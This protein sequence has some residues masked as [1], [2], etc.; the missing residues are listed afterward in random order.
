M[1]IGKGLLL[2]TVTALGLVATTAAIV[3][4]YKNKQDDL[5]LDDDD[6]DENANE[7]EEIKDDAHLGNEGSMIHATDIAKLLPGLASEK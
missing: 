2:G 7:D 5:S 1:T 3:T 6:E 4:A